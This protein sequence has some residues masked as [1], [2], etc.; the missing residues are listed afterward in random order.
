MKTLEKIILE[1]DRALVLPL[2]GYRTQTLPAPVES[3][4]KATLRKARGFYKPQGIYEIYP[5][6]QATPQG[7]VVFGEGYIFQ[8]TGIARL[9]RSAEA[10]ALFIVTI[11]PFLED[12][13]AELAQKGEITQSL[14][15]E[16]VGSAAAE[17]LAQKM[18]EHIEAEAR[19]QGWKAT[20]RYSPG[21]C[22]WDLTQQKVLFSALAGEAIGVTLNPQCIM[23]PRKSISALIGLGKAVDTGFSLC[24][25]CTVEG[26]RARR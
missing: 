24:R 20:L 21:Y 8:S 5:L 19:Q 14:L 10:L 25:D 15:L 23:I 17:A 1:V 4:L 18:Q 16:A 6:K 9:L 11:G 2:L 13:A 22:D 3:L 7:R 12:E 26:C